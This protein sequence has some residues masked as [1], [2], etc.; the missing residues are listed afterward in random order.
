[1]QGLES[2]FTL[3]RNVAEV[4]V[5]GAATIVMPDISWC[6]DFFLNS[7]IMSNNNGSHWSSFDAFVE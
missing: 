7:S 2:S 4:G 3:A 6:S 5:C 1:M